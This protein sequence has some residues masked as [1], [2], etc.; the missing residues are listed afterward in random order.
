MI[1][2]SV[3][4]AA[5][6]VQA[7]PPL[8]KK[9]RNQKENIQFP[10]EAASWYKW[11]PITVVVLFSRS[12]ISS[13]LFPSSVSC[14]SS[15]LFRRQASIRISLAEAPCS[16]RRSAQPLLFLD[17]F[18]NWDH[19]RCLPHAPPRE[20]WRK[21]SSRQ[22]KGGTTIAAQYT[23]FRD[24]FRVMINVFGRRDRQRRSSGTLNYH[25]TCLAGKCKELPRSCDRVASDGR[26]LF[27]R[28]ERTCN[29]REVAVTIITMYDR[30]APRPVFWNLEAPLTQCCVTDPQRGPRGA[31]FSAWGP[32]GS[33]ACRGPPQEVAYSHRA[34]QKN[35]QIRISASKDFHVTTPLMM[36]H[37]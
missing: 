34:G 23:R 24:S 27:G 29:A 10:C 18:T 5:R 28:K 22:G 14:I 11:L 20:T 19:Q 2:C 13:S 15:T 35:H 25:K 7:P 8:P 6:A 9:G 17:C 37:R 4:S 3:A 21:R 31:C 33:F 32:L 16:S 36:R 30:A 26:S 12:A 1:S